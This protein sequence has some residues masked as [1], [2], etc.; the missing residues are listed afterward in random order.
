MDEGIVGRWPV[1]RQ[2]RQAE[3][4]LKAEILAG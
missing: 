1:L 3:G 2:L 4:V